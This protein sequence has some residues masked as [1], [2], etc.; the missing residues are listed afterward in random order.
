[1]L[2]LVCEGIAAGL[3]PIADDED[4]RVLLDALEQ[5][6]AKQTVTAPVTPPTP[7][8]TN[9]TPTPPIVVPPTDAPRPTPPVVKPAPTRRRT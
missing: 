1:M 7:K 3:C 9:P 6:A 5:L 2:D 8:P 4:L